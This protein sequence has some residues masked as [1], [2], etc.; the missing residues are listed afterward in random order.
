MVAREAA[1]GNSFH[2]VVVACSMDLW[3]WKKQARTDPKGA[4]AIVK[5]WH[6][7]TAVR[8]FNDIGEKDDA[9]THVSES[10]RDKE[11]E[12]ALVQLVRNPKREQWLRL[13]GHIVLARMEEPAC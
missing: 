11:E 1:I 8:R 12:E 6:E 9:T 4:S 10:E 13:A 5:R 3:L 7:E 2:T